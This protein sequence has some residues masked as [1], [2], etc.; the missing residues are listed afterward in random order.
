MRLPVVVLATAAIALSACAAPGDEDTASVGQALCRGV[1]VSNV[2]VRQGS[3]Y[4]LAPDALLN[5]A[6]AWGP[7]TLLLSVDRRMGSTLTL[8]RQPAIQVAKDQIT[9][10][11]QETTGINLIRDIELTA[12]SSTEVPP[13]SYE[14]L[15][16]YPQYQVITLD[17][18][19]DGCGLMPDQ[20]LTSGTIYRPMGVYFRVVVM[21]GKP[22]KTEERP[23]YGSIT[24]IGVPVVGEEATRGEH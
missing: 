8:L 17:L 18:R 22:A 20:F 24:A 7:Q 6:E 19:Q 12:S 23:Q 4:S 2:S 5:S 9:K 21:A 10:S 14:R 16:A 1:Y 11:I 13:G 15:E 3:F